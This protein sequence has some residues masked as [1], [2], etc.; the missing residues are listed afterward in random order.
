M[1]LRGPERENIRINVKMIHGYNCNTSI[2]DLVYDPILF[3]KL[4]ESD[5]DKI[6]ILNIKLCDNCKFIRELILIGK[7]RGD[8]YSSS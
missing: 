6:I 3:E 4:L 8:V 1:Y 2:I 7:D 5:K